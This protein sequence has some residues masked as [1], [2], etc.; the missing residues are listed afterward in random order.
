MKAEVTKRKLAFLRTIKTL[1]ETK[2]SLGGRY[3]EKPKAKVTL[4][5]LMCLESKPVE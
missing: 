3:K 4:P 2:Y 5:K 1:Q